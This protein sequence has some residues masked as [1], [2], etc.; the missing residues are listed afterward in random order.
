MPDETRIDVVTAL[1][2]D[3]NRLHHWRGAGMKLLRGVARLQS[4]MTVEQARA[5]LSTRLA[6]SRAQGPKLY[7]QDVSL[8]V[9]PLRDSVVKDVRAVAVVLMG[10][11]ASILL[12]ASANVASLLMARAA[13]RG[14]EMAV[15]VALGCKR[16]TDRRLLLVEGVVIGLVGATA[17][18]VLAGVLLGL[19]PQ[20]RPSTLPSIEAVGLNSDVIGA[21]IGVAAFLRWP[22]AWPPLCFCRA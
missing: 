22:S 3:E 4:G 13:G 18:I 16:I 2:L 15:R 8:R 17:G 12:I 20:L 21:A 19:V 1:A 5:E 14:R 6:S 7:G 11:V 9:I 10:A